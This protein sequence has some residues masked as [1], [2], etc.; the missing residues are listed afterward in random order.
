VQTRLPS[1]L[2]I[3]MR[4]N[5]NAIHLSSS[6]PHF[7]PFGRPCARRQRMLAWIASRTRGQTASLKSLQTMCQRF[8]CIQCF[9][10]SLVLHL[11][12]QMPGF[13]VACAQLG[14]LA[15]GKSCAKLA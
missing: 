10:S 12:H 15:A 9:G 7:I 4:A 14:A 8:G 1:G 13:D 5:A 3:A 11:G 6:C 2:A